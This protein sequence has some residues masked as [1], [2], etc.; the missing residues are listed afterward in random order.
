MDLI[1][2]K[3]KESSIFQTLS[4]L[5]HHTY[6]DK[7]NLRDII[8]FDEFKKLLEIFIEEIM[9]DYLIRMRFN[10]FESEPPSCEI[11]IM[12]AEGEQTNNKIRINEV[13]VKKIYD[14]NIIELFVACHELIHFKYW[15]LIS[16]RNI[17]VDIMRYLKETL[18]QLDS[19]EYYDRNYQYIAPEKIANIEGVELF[20]KLINFMDIDLSI[21]DRL[22]LDI[23]YEKNKLEYQ[24][25]L[26]IIRNRQTNEFSH[27]NFEEAFDNLIKKYPRW[28][29]MFKL[30]IEYY[31]DNFGE[32]K[33]WSVQELKLILEKC[34]NKDIN[35]YIAYML[36]K[37]LQFQGES[38]HSKRFTKA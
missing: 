38:K 34:D 11:L 18:M 14:G 7:G 26:R 10:N 29:Q 32:V 24:N 6:I 17:N 30:K 37:R 33:K 12:E 3:I 21:Y 35:Q 22:E 2:D 36:D 27:M 15:N 19:K 31:L 9:K 20:Y 1:T 5:L 16:T 23:I 13:I 28:A 4:Q 8:S 25:P